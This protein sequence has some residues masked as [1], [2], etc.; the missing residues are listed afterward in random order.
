MITEW[1]VNINDNTFMDMKA[2]FNNVLKKTLTNMELKESD[3]AEITLKLK[4]TV[5][6][7]NSPFEEPIR[8]IVVPK[9]DHRVSSV[10]QI[11]DEAI[12][13]LGGNCELV[14]DTIAGEW[15][16]REIDTGQQSLFDEPEEDTDEQD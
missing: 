13:S 3:A 6:R 11:K 5:T 7:E 9:F 16:M 8:E 2:D 14:F 12:G 10:M 15:V 1:P 4:I